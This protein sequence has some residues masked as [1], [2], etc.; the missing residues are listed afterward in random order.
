MREENI[1]ELWGYFEH[2]VGW[3]PSPLPHGV[4]KLPTT[5]W[6]IHSLLHRWYPLPNKV[7][8][9][10]LHGGGTYHMRWGTP[11][12]MVGVPNHMGWVHPTP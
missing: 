8:Y 11:Y 3:E 10:L 7:G 5:P 2:M 4:K 9:T 1:F 12:S 6:K